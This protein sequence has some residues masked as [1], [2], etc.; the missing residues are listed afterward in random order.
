MGKK[1]KVLLNKSN[2]HSKSSCSYR[3]NESP[4]IESNP[5]SV[6]PWG[7]LGRERSGHSPNSSFSKGKSSFQGFNRISE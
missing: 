4:E 6:K 3:K 5:I 2:W 1:L 7:S